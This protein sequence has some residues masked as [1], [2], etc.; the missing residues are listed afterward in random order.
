MSA[1]LDRRML[2][3]AGLLACR[4]FG[5]VE[6]NPMVG[7]IIGRPDGTPL[8]LGHHRRFGAAHAE[9]EA[10]DHCR[11]RGHDPRGSTAWVTLEPCTH[12]GKTP[13]C[14]RALIDAGIARV[15]IARVD[16]HPAAAGGIDALRSAGITVD[17]I[18]DESSL[19]TSVS[20]PFIKRI[21]TGLPWV[22]AKWAQTIDGRIA[23]R[24]GESQWITGPAARR[25][26]H[27]LRG[28]VDAILTGIGTVHADDPQLTCRGVTRRRTARR[29][30]LDPQLETPRGSRL[31]QSINDA[32]VTILTG[33]AA[34]ASARG[35]LESLGAEVQ[36]LPPNASGLDIAAG[37]RHLVSAHDLTTV[38]TEAGAG[39]LGR[40]LSD[41]LI[42]EAWVYVGSQIIGDAEAPG[43]FRGASRPRLADASAFRLLQSRRLGEDMLL[44]YR[45]R[46]D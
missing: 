26:V 24:A 40:L 7:C 19:A 1:P 44:R 36:V 33:A 34:P 14:A 20:A 29:V 3:R 9:V 28:R 11:V 8:G 16:P 12:S 35:A 4:G 30:V 43:A 22:I 27:A 42:D 41:D 5:S 46:R 23:T 39:V 21:T 25:H 10:L 37:L 45:R 31:M 15:V 32:P 13:P 18:E 2:H 38:M 6:P 17:I